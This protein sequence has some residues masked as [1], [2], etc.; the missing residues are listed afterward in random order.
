MAKN[1]LPDGTRIGYAKLTIS[2]E[3]EGELGEALGKI[4]AE[5]GVRV[6]DL[7]GVLVV[8]PKPHGDA[9]HQIVEHRVSGRYRPKKL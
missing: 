5:L 6:I 3:P 7:E 1:L 4:A 8:I 2:S 9:L